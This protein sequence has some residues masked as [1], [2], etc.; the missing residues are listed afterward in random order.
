MVLPFEDDPEFDEYYAVERTKKGSANNASDSSLTSLGSQT[1]CVLASVKSAERGTCDT[2]VCMTT[3]LSS[4]ARAR[5]SDDL[6]GL[7]E[8]KPRPARKQLVGN[9]VAD[10]AEEV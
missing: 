2:G 1:L 10:V 7:F 9:P 3:F 4:V 6:A 8:I 5:R